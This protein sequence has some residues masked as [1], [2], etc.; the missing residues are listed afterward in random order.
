MLVG[1]VDEVAEILP[2]PEMRIDVEEILDT[3]AVIACELEC[4]LAEDRLTQ[5]AVTRRLRYPSLLLS[6]F[7]VPPAICRRPYQVS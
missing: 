1:G 7:S 2:R 4:G 5:R 6:P 3:V